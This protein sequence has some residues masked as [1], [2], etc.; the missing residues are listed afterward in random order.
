MSTSSKDFGVLFSELTSGG[1]SKAV[2]SK[3][4]TRLRQ[5]GFSIVEIRTAQALLNGTLG[6]LNEETSEGVILYHK[7]R[8]R[9][10]S[11]SSSQSEPDPWTIVPQSSTEVSGKSKSPEAGE[12]KSVQVDEEI[13]S[14]LL[15]LSSVKSALGVKDDQ[16]NKLIQF[17]T[18]A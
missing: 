10:Q 17:L 18:D 1:S 7:E 3:K 8:H 15:E 12:S 9:H 2:R 4:N 14:K 6:L 13:L 16:L 5:H 11:A